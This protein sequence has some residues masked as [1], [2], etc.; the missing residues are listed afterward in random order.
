MTIFYYRKYTEVTA[1]ASGFFS[2]INLMLNK[3]KY[4]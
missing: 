1:L 2:I 4:K 3:T